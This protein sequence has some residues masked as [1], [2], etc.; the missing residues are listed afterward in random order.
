MYLLWTLDFWKFLWTYFLCLI[1]CKPIFYLN[2]SL[3]IDEQK[4][5][6]E[7]KHHLQLNGAGSTIQVMSYDKV[8]EVIKN[9]V[10]TMEGKF[11]VRSRSSDSLMWSSFCDSLIRKELKHC[12]FS[13]SLITWTESSSKL[14]WSP[15]VCSPSV[16]N[17]LDLLTYSPEP[18]VQFQSQVPC[19]QYLAQSKVKFVWMDAKFSL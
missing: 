15:I 17:L 6:A 11:W 19:M 16:C 3:F 13:I 9:L 18:L 12:T 4:L 10:D 1:T 5:D 8:G 7:V 14:I 2:C